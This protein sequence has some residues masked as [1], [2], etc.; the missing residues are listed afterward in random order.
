MFQLVAIASSLLS[1]ASFIEAGVIR[2]CNVKLGDIIVVMDASSSIGN[3]NFDIQKNFVANV[4][5]AFSVSP[6]EV[7]FG[8]LIFDTNPTKKFDLKD[9]LDNDS[10]SKAILS[11]KYPYL[12]GTHTHKALKEILSQKMFGTEAGGRDKA[13]NIVIVVTDGLSTYPEKTKLAVQEVKSQNIT[14]VAIGIGPHQS[15]AELGIIAS[16]PSLVFSVTEYSVLYR[17]EKDLSKT[18]CEVVTST[19]T[20][21]TVAPT[22]ERPTCPTQPTTTTTEKPTCPTQP[23]TT[24]TEKPTCPTQPTTTTTTTPTTTTTTTTTEEPTTT[25]EKPTTTTEEPTTTTEEPTTT[26]EEPTTTTEEPTTTTEEPTT[27]T[28]TTEEPTTTTEEPTTTTEEPTTTT[29]E[30]TTTTEEL[31]TTTTTTEEP[32]TTT[33]EPTTT[34]TTTRTTT[35]PYTRPPIPPSTP[36]PCKNNTKAD[37][38][39]VI[40]ASTS[41]GPTKWLNQTLFASTVTSYFNVGPEEVQFG[42]LIFNAAPV[43][44]FDLKTYSDHD[45]LSKALLDVKYPNYSGTFTHKALNAVYDWKMFDEAAGGR[46]DAPNIVIL[47]TDGLSQNTT[48]TVQ[49]A[50]NLKTSLDA[51][52]LAVGIGKDVNKEELKEVA[53]DSKYVFFSQDYIVLDYISKDL[54]SIT[55]NTAKLLQSL[56]RAKVVPSVNSELP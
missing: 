56:Y 8:A 23:T 9:Y 15:K 43:K 17:I 37:I 11:I 54:I 40:D 13:P 41:I 38:I 19:T 36:T 10:L 47:M 52:V 6:T 31:T 29:E 50:N 26:T 25:T 16:D 2:T 21:T 20:T 7:R 4:T 18:A 22:T 35:T 46:A 1:M 32:T 24:T 30:P 45:A 5:G 55:C 51:T 44:L 39:L 48:K 14:I 12:S 53:S 42:A 33:E 28:T 27:T 34:T 49:A 3:K